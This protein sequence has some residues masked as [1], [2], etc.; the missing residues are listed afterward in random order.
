LALSHFAKQAKFYA[1]FRPDYPHELFAFVASVAPR[2]ELAWDCA[3]GNGQAAVGL[4][5][6]FRKVI[7]TDI[8]AEQIAQARLHPRVE[9]RVGRAEASGLAAKSVDAV[10]VCQALHWLHVPGFFAEVRR[11]LVPGGVLVAT[12]YS[13]AMIADAALDPLLQH[14]NKT[15]AG[16]YWPPERKIV[17]EQYRGIV[18][19]FEEI[20]VPSLELFRDWNLQQLAGYVRSWSATVRYIEKKG[21][22]PTEDLERELAARWGD[23]NKPKRIVWPF[24]IKAS[25]F[26]G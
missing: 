17:N 6:H 19:P 1:Q 25:K 26:R 13:D 12:V 11:V 8:S 7:A 20:P 24:T 16:E 15:I 23:P 18:F 21:K 3:T 5:E 22:D 10:T 14:Y 4:A 2:R 9:Y